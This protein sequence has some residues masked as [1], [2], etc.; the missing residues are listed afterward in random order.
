MKIKVCGITS[1]EQLE[2][3]REI[4]ADYAGLIFYEGSNRF[5]GE[6]I[7]NSKL[8]IQ[9]TDIKKIG[10]FVNAELNVVK[11]TIKDFRLYGVQLHGDETDEFCLELM[12]KTKVIKAFRIGEAQNIDELV[13]PFH[14]VCDYYLFDTSQT[15]HSE[16]E[17]KVYGGSGEKFDW[18][19]LQQAKISKPF[20]LSGGIAVD[21]VE[22]IK[23]F[24]HPFFYAVDI[25]SRFETE[26]GVKN[27]E[28]VQSFINSF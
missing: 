27:M 18:N 19:I 13:K 6:R 28:K 4:G 23:Q 14:S 7:K 25:N 10:V 17:K 26:P 20:Y 3:L 22:K 1:S 11:K 12:D 24:H 9:N 21:D 15:K 8:K 5:A 2:K 16:Q